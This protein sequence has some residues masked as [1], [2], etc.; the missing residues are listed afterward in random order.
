VKNNDWL[1]YNVNQLL[2]IFY[3]YF[4][5]KSS[6]SFLANLA[7]DLFYCLLICLRLLDA[8]IYLW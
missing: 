5:M 1:S 4:L 8:F 6:N 3:F 2:S 7:G